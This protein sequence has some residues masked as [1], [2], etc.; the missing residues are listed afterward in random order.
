MMNDNNYVLKNTLKKMLETQLT[1]NY[2]N[3]YFNFKRKENNSLEV[4]SRVTKFPTIFQFSS[5][6]KEDFNEELE[7]IKDAVLFIITDDI[8]Q[9]ASYIKEITFEVIDFKEHLER[10]GYDPNEVLIQTDNKI[11]E[12]YELTLTIITKIKYIPYIPEEV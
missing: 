12:F 11:K 8:A 2:I 3:S 9:V 10:N 5:K 1:A 7:V 6:V 4:L